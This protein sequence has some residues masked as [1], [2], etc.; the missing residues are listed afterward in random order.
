M[1]ATI[2]SINAAGFIAFRHR[3]FSYRGD[4]GTWARYSVDTREL[5]VQ[6]TSTGRIS[7]AYSDEMR[8]FCASYGID[9][10]AMRSGQRAVVVI[11]A[12]NPDAVAVAGHARAVALDADARM[13]VAA[14]KI[15]KATDEDLA[16]TGD[17][18][19][20]ALRQDFVDIFCS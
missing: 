8:E 4:K 14:H 6:C 12:D 2:A 5:T 15:G 9:W 18:A 13:D 16:A 3:D 11:D 17:A 19:R 1:T 20:D 7:E 10:D